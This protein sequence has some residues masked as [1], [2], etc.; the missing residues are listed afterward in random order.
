MEK[1]AGN[2]ETDR[3]SVCT[4]S[5]GRVRPKAVQVGRGEGAEARR[6]G[7]CNLW[8]APQAFDIPKA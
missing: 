8:E 5:S 1:P 3:K 6:R 7:L 4:G 2:D